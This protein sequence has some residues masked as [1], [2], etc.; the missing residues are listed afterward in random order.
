MEPTGY[1]SFPISVAGGYCHIDDEG[2]L[3][4]EVSKTREL[5]IVGGPLLWIS[6]QVILNMGVLIVRGS[7]FRILGTTLRLVHRSQCPP[8]SYIVVEWPR[9]RRAYYLYRTQL[10]LEDINWR[11]LT[12]LKI[13]GMVRSELYGAVSW[14][15]VK[16]IGR[17][18]GLGDAIV[19]VWALFMY[20]LGR[21]TPWEEIKERLEDGE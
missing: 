16:L 13:W 21:T 8:W 4:T 19:T 5:L 6:E 1:I 12:T 15:D 7:I 17:L 10:F 2:R 3:R 11:I 20:R 9:H 14:K 18:F